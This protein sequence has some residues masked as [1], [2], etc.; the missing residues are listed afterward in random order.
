MFRTKSDVAAD[1]AGKQT[2]K[3]RKQ[4]KKATKE[5][6]KVGKSAAARGEAVKGSVLSS[7]SAGLHSLSD[8]MAPKAAAAAGAAKGGA[9]NARSVA[10]DKT[11]DAR[12]AAL[13]R[14][15]D[16]RAAAMD[17]TADA[18]E[19]AKER[20]AQARNSAVSGLD[21]GVDAAVPVMQ[22]GVSDVSEKVDHAR[23]RLVDDVLPRLQEMLNNAQSS[24]DDVLAKSDG[25]VATVTG[26]PK[27]SPKKG[28]FLI[29]FG[30]L[31]AIGAGVAYYLSQQKSTTEDDTDPWA[32]SADSGT[33]AKPKNGAAQ[34][35]VAGPVETSTTTTEVA[36]VHSDDAAP[37]AV[38]SY[39]A[40]PVAHDVDDTHVDDTRVEASGASTDGDIAETSEIKEGEELPVMIEVDD[41]PGT[42]P[43]AQA[44]FGTDFSDT[45]ETNEGK[46][47][48]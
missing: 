31:A 39:G 36:E 12:A 15:A 30:I 18:R 47:R 8:A 20:A 42:D 40:T 48:A 33:T 26:A 19:A 35:T 13:D 22:Q 2:K 11:A 34:T 25:R 6:K 4:G 5:A 3:A 44:G 41:V 45:D 24:K 17:R 1:K 32:G 43:D 38:D 10:L 27:K 21:R 37:V 7:V 23:D 46:H 28:G 29:V 16:A 9:S 14:T